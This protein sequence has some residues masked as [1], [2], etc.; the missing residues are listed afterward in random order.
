VAIQTP[1]SIVR[2]PLYVGS[3]LMALGSCIIINDDENIWFIPIAAFLLYFPN[4]RNEEQELRQKFGKK[5]QSHIERT[6]V[7]FPRKIP[8][9]LSLNWSLN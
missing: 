4:I 1:Y 2:H 3:L 7:F 5:W 6:G 8:P 9:N